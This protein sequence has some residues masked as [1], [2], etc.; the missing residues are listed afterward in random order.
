MC[1]MPPSGS[2]RLP[3]FGHPG[4]SFWVLAF[5]DSGYEPWYEGFS[6]A[7]AV[8]LLPATRPEMCI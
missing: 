2:C 1:I 8:T 5:K 7:M 3:P 6:A 4:L